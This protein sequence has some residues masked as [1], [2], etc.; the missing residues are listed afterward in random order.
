MKTS[1]PHPARYSHPL[2]FVLLTILAGLGLLLGGCMTAGEH[3]DAVRD[4][5]KGRL[6]VGTV[7]REI[8]VG[9]SGAQVTEV[10][11]APNIVTTDEN[12]REVW[13]YDKISTEVTYSKSEGGLAALI[14][15]AIGSG[16][17]GLL[18]SANQSAGASSQSQRTLTVVIK[19]DENKVVRDFSYHQSSF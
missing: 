17:G 10:L 3:R 12:R 6:S 7:Q 5:T 13:I 16:G 18:G 15:G 8:H 2:S 4:D 11:G 19:F 1:L 9:M 14:F